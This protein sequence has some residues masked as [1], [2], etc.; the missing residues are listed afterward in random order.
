[1]KKKNY[2]KFIFG[3]GKFFDGIWYL[4][5][6]PVLVFGCTISDDVL[7]LTNQ[8]P[9]IHILVLFAGMITLIFVLGSCISWWQ[10]ERVLSNI[11][12]SLEDDLKYCY[13]RMIGIDMRLASLQQPDTIS[14][15]VI[16]FLRFN[17]ADVDDE[18]DVVISKTITSLNKDYNEF[19]QDITNFGYLEL[20]K[21][22]RSL[23]DTSERYELPKLKLKMKSLEFIKT[24]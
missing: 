8:N 20:L 10:R 6:A 19:D 3:T 18:R 5:C 17:Y 7:Q 16:N 12:T 2:F 24:S 21:K 22:L 13:K 9:V 15:D 23:V 11:Y 14:D 4:L 1:M